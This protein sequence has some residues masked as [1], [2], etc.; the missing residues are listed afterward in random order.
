MTENKSTLLH[1]MTI[2]PD[3]HPLH[4]VYL[5]VTTLQILGLVSK[6]IRILALTAIQ[7]CSVH[8]GVEEAWPPYPGPAQLIRLIAG[9]QLKQLYASVSVVSSTFENGELVC[10]QLCNHD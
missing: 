7:R 1:L 6:N 8:F 9:T 2:L 10:Q 3:L 4:L 5:D